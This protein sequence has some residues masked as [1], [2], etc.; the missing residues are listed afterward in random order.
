MALVLL[1]G[2]LAMPCHRNAFDVL[3]KFF[4]T[5]PPGSWEER[6]TQEAQAE[7]SEVKCKQGRQGRRQLTFLLA[8]QDYGSRSAR[9]VSS[10]CSG[11]QEGRGSSTAFGHESVGVTPE[12]EQQQQQQQQRE[13][14]AE[15]AGRPC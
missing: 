4:K 2:L 14:G 13:L 11:S 10:R 15:N 6:H 9:G 3:D 12:E 7:P 8:A 1:L 5:R